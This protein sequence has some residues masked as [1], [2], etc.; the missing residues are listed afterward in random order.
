MDSVILEDID[1]ELLMFLRGR[2]LR[3]E[4]ILPKVTEDVL[5]KQEYMNNFKLLLKCMGKR[6]NKDIA[7]DDLG[8]EISTR[9][10]ERLDMLLVLKN[11]RR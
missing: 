2:R 1:L 3:F 7:S 4:L 10:N 9:R 6:R 8:V 5:T 11:A